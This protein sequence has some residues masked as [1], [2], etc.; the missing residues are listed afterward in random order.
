MLYFYTGLRTGK[1]ESPNMKTGI[2][3]AAKWV[4]L[5]LPFFQYL[6]FTANLSFLFQF[7]FASANL[8]YRKFTLFP[9]IPHPQRLSPLNSLPYKYSRNSDKIITFAY[10]GKLKS[11][12]IPPFSKIYQ[13]PSASKKTS[14]FQPGYND[15]I[16]FRAGS[17]EAFFNYI[18]DNPRRYLVRKP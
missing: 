3:P 16:A 8:R 11:P 9:R 14:M 7:R 4:T 2:T 13:D 12:G 5:C 18:A 6:F 10:D 1:A 15:K 17:K